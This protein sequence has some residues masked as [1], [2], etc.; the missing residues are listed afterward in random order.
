M[1]KFSTVLW[2]GDWGFLDTFTLRR[3]LDGGGNALLSGEIWAGDD[4][5][6]PTTFF[7][8]YLRLTGVMAQFFPDLNSQVYPESVSGLAGMPGG[9]PD[10]LT[11]DIDSYDLNTTGEPTALFT[12]EVRAQ[13]DDPA[14]ATNQATYPTGV[15][16]TP[17]AGRHVDNGNFRALY[18]GFGIEAMDDVDSDIPF[19]DLLEEL[20]FDVFNPAASITRVAPRKLTTQGGR[21]RIIGSNFQRTGKTIVRVGSRIVPARVVSRT[22]IRAT[23][24]SRFRPGLYDVKVTNPIG[25]QVKKEDALR[26]VRG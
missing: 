22:E 21:F 1:K 4:R 13:N 2:L 14:V 12:D 20:V 18:L 5:R 17:L 11:L 25:A 3:Y 10:G 16:P 8:D 19:V 9:F 15:N 26:V 6:F 24:P 7:R 23:L